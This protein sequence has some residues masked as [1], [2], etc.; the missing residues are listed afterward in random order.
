MADDI[1]DE[2]S[3]AMRDGDFVQEFE[4]GSNKTKFMT[5]AQVKALAD[6]EEEAAARRSRK[7]NGGNIFRRIR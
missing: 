5:P 2:Y 7:K 1:V 4:E 6:L 3:Q